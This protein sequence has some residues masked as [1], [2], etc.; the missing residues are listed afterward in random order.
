MITE[1]KI[2]T[3]HNSLIRDLRR[4]GIREEDIPILRNNRTLIKTD[5]DNIQKTYSINTTNELFVP[6]MTEKVY[7]AYYNEYQHGMVNFGSQCNVKCFYCT[8][9]YNPPDLH[10]PYNSF[11]TV[12][13]IKSLLTVAPKTID[14]GSTKWTTGGE[15][16]LHPDIVEILNYMYDEGF[17]ISGISTN[18]KLI[19]NEIAKILSKWKNV[20][21]GLHL[22]AT[23]YKELIPTL[24]LLDKYEIIYDIVIVPTRSRIDNKRI[25]KWIENVQKHR[26]DS[27]CILKPSFTKF[28]PPNIR[29]E[30]DI[31]DTEL[32][33]LVGYWN[34]K[35]TNHKVFL[36]TVRFHEM[37]ILSSLE[38][39]SVN[40]QQQTFSMS[41]NVLFLI[42][43]SV[44]NVFE[45]IVDFKNKINFITEDF[46]PFA[47]YKIKKVKNKTFG[48][49]CEVSGL[50]MCSDY[51]SAVNDVIDEGYAPQ[52]I[53][54]SKESFI[55][56]DLD[57][58]GI[59]ASSISQQFELPLIWC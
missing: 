26:I 57:L 17:V 36:Q 27:V 54:T 4:R 38:Y 58:R 33:E 45:E 8:Q 59:H 25:E 48:G 11:L 12:D 22:S 18:G 44:E 53:V 28:T 23:S 39:F 24:D 31:S 47:N 32:I 7:T 37:N 49:N 1:E 3:E 16:F 9:Y 5:N 52:F 29:K 35:Y 50:L 42:A 15:V 30:L 46:S 20:S 55:F 6:G 34:F 41:P 21:I 40:Y 43:E 19:T 14:L 10:I 2:K 13:E 56:D 51:I